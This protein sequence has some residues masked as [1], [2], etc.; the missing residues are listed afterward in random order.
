MSAEVRHD[1]IGDG[2]A[3][4]L[5]AGRELR[6]AARR[7]SV[8]ITMAVLFAASVAAVV[9]PEILSTD[10]DD[11]RTVVTA[12][13]VPPGFDEVVAEVGPAVDLTITVTPA[14]EMA[15]ADGNPPTGAPAGGEPPTSAPAAGEPPTSAPAGAEP[16]TADPS[17]ASTDPEST[18]PAVALV[19]DGD[20]DAAVVFGAEGITILTDDD[21]D[22]RLLAALRQSAQVVTT[23]ELLTD[24]GVPEADIAQVTGAAPV[25]VEILDTEQG[26]RQGVAL[27]SSLAVYLLLMFLAMQVANGVAVEK[28]NRVSEVLLAVVSP[29]AL[30][31]GKVVGVGLIGLATIVVGTLPLVARLVL[32]GSVPPGTG[33]TLVVSVAFALVSIALYLS[34]AGALGA[35]VARAEDVGS[36]VGPIT[37]V[38]IGGYLVGQF[39]SGSTLGIVL[40]YLPLTS[41]MVM[42]ARVALDE[43]GLAGVLLSL[44]LGVATVAVAV[45]FASVVYRRA[46]VRT[47]ERLHLAEVL[48]SSAG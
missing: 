2:A 6:E 33:P 15:A 34:V 7:K 47:G 36:T 3:L 26:G 1:G 28:S 22:Q 11:D 27:A 37:V 8:W 45:R 48:R 9:L 21:S 31:F 42:P 5:V 13:D 46:I 24:A 16:P 25:S 40:S 29:R 18:D 30:L 38:L 12:G 32:G 20:A 23:T 41:A 10:P 4:W 35:L 43:V 39:A 44:A 17:G 19:S 14:A